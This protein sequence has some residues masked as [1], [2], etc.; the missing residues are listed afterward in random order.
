MTGWYGI[1]TFQKLLRSTFAF[2]SA[3]T[4]EGD[5]YQNSNRGQK[6]DSL[7][8]NIRKCLSVCFNSFSLTSNHMFTQ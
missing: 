1:L 6:L 3:D 2:S 5:V 7:Q 4:E 8:S